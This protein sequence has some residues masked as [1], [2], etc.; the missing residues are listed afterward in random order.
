MADEGIMSTRQ[1]SEKLG[2]LEYSLPFMQQLENNPIFKVGFDPEHVYYQREKGRKD[3]GTNIPG[4]YY[5]AG[6]SE[7]GIKSGIERALESKDET[8]KELTLERLRELQKNIGELGEGPY[9]SSDPDK[10][11]TDEFV[12]MEEPAKNLR[13]KENLVTT[14]HEFVHRAFRTTPELKNF[15]YK[16][17]ITGKQRHAI[18]MYMIGQEFPEFKEDQYETAKNQYKVDLTDKRTEQKY[19]NLYNEIVKI[20]ENILDK[21]LEEGRAK[22]PVVSMQVEEETKKS[23]TNKLKEKLGFSQGGLVSINYLTRRL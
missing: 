21:R 7:K 6:I 14:V 18:I 2:D 1:A 17:K 13:D 15:F 4:I 9:T 19:A 23:W 8:H 11:R 22:E 20:S 5:P 16:N 12:W 3:I 10:K